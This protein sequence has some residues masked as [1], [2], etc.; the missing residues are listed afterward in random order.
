MSPTAPR[1]WVTRT[2]PAALQTAD[3]LRAFG[4][5]PDLR[6]L[7][8]VRPVTGTPQLDGVGALAFTSVNGVNEFA[9]RVRRRYLPVFA[10]GDATAQA[11]LAA[12]FV[13]VRS[14]GGDIGDLTRLVLAHRD[15]IRGRLLW[16][17]AS[18]PAGDL[19]GALAAGGVQAAGCVLYETVPGL[20]DEE[21]V[22]ALETAAD[23]FAAVLVYS[24]KAGRR[25]AKALTG[26]R[27][28][29]TFACI[30][31]A[32]ADPLTRSGLRATAAARPNEAHMLRGL[33]EELGHETLAKGAQ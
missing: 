11:A 7:L 15:Q 30:S 1:V 26:R 20:D 17:G 8:T 5:R 14:A 28:A 32:A 16:A 4:L 6:P 13:Q 25:L 19:V 2:L 31:Q 10:V 21:I 29:I 18:E 3:R 23:P 9:R 22:A 27:P 24:P 33:L 12:G